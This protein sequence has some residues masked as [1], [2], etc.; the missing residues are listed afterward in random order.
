M[1]SNLIGSLMITAALLAA[2][3][4]LTATA[5]GTQPVSA[6]SG[7]MKGLAKQKVVFQVSDADPKKWNLTLNNVK[8]IQHDLGKGNADIEVVA[9]G[10]GIAMLKLDSEVGTRVAEALGSGVQVVA[11]GNTMT[12][13]KLTKE[14]ML[15]NLGYVKAGVVELME[16]QQQGY[17][18]I[19]P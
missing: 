13:L 5:A 7:E 11:C 19:R 6:S 16:K 4:S 18:Y 1:K 8:N 12:N 15:P 10:P 3:A 17:A 2:G 14:D 9:Y